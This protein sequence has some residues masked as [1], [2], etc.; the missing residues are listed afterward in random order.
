MD[1]SEI[2]SDNWLINLVADELKELSE[3]LLISLTGK[4]VGKSEVDFSEV[5]ADRHRSYSCEQV[6]Y[7]V[8]S[9]PISFSCTS[10]PKL[11]RINGVDI[12]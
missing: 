1:V 11:C 3:C 10:R 7:E 12:E 8:E 2:I 6:A 5:H 9:K 4:S